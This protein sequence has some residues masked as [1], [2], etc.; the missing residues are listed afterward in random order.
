MM[1][2]CFFLHSRRA[3]RHFL[4]TF[5]RRTRRTLEESLTRPKWIR[6]ARL[7]EDDRWNLIHAATV[8]ELR[9][10]F[11]LYKTRRLGF[12]L[13]CVNFSDRSYK[14]SRKTE[15]SS[16]ERRPSRSSTPVVDDTKLK[17][18][19]AHS[20]TS[21]KRDESSEP[22]VEKIETPELNEDGY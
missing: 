5:A 6:A 9:T 1:V 3:S 19:P 11:R 18:S 21:K 12:S 7:V 14:P 4:Q 13:N 17:P 8:D 20:S 10:G 16:A 2:K 22:I 15:T